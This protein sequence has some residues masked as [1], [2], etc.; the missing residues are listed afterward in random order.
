M[1][2]N[3]E[4]ELVV[5][6]RPSGDVARTRLFAYFGGRRYEQ[7]ECDCRVGMPCAQGHVGMSPRC[8]IW[9]A[10]SDE[11]KAK[12]IANSFDPPLV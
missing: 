12:R 1:T 7:V 6:N 10:D 9:K 5:A 3:N 4:I 11:A 2:E 8:R